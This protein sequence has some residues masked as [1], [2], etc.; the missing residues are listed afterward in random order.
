MNRIKTTLAVIV[1]LLFVF[2][3]GANAADVGKCFKSVDK[4]TKKIT[5]ELS[6]WSMA[7]YAK[8][9]NSLGDILDKAWRKTAKCLDKQY[10]PKK[11]KKPLKTGLM[12]GAEAYKGTDGEDWMGQG[13]INKCIPMALEAYEGTEKTMEKEGID[14]LPKKERKS[15]MKPLIKNQKKV[16]KG[17]V[18][19][20]FKKENSAYKKRLSKYID[21]HYKEK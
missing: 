4:A 9:S 18:G 15:K 11:G 19:Y 17:T 10:K 14:K 16:I 3:A 13:L 5:K 21:K 12:R 6:G 1:A 2:S 20:C 7:K 8:K